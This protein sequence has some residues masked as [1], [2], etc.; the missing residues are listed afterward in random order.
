MERKIGETFDFVGVTLEVVELLDVKDAI[1]TIA[2]ECFG[3]PEVR[4][5]LVETRQK[6]L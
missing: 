2:C 5:A 1:S 3:I 6:S 4:V